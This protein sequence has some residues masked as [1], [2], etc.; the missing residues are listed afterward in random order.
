MIRQ[1]W[2]IV[3]GHLILWLAGDEPFLINASVG[4]DQR[5]G[6]YFEHTKSGTILWGQINSL[7]R[8]N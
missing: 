1:I 2:F 3:K 7:K 4:Y 5:D 6:L 8:R